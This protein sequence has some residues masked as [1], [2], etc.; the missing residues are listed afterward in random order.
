MIYNYFFIWGILIGFISLIISTTR[1]KNL[2]DADKKKD[3]DPLIILLTFVAFII[4][5]II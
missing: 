2:N 3:K 5:C 4:Y 1:H